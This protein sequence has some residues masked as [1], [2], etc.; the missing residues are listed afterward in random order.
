M[1]TE[2]PGPRRSA[3]LVTQ[4]DTASGDPNEDQGRVGLY[5]DAVGPPPSSLG[6]GLLPAP[7]T[8]VLC[9]WPPSILPSRAD[10]SGL[11]TMPASV[12][13]PR[14]SSLSSMSL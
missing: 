5:S 9:S 8:H 3:I 6:P 2:E 10:G 1:S 7:G 13:S 11:L 12:L 14:F 4:T